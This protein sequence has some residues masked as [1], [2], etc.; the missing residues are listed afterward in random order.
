MTIW[1]QAFFYQRQRE[2]LRN[3]NGEVLIPTKLKQ[4]HPF[5][6]YAAKPI[7]LIKTEKIWGTKRVP[8]WDKTSYPWEDKNPR[9]TYKRVYF[10]YYLQKDY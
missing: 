10:A 5:F 3:I 8:W 9:W 1:P 4:K 2:T 7:S 6:F